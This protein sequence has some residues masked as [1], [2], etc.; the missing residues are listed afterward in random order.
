MYIASPT[1][2]IY[3]VLERKKE[4][5][6]RIQQKGTCRKRLI[7]AISGIMPESH[8]TAISPRK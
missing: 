6:E 4:K 3:V 5:E 8:L 7:G 2:E 1:R